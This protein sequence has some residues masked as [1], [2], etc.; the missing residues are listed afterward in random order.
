EVEANVA[1]GAPPAQL[2][3]RPVLAAGAD[4]PG[5][6]LAAGALEED[7]ARVDEPQRRPRLPE[8]AEEVLQRRAVEGAVPADDAVVLAA[9]AVGPPGQ[10][11]DGAALAGA[12]RPV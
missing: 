10:R 7:V 2:L 12:R 5:A 11:D 8:G 9:G 3:R 1:A 4:R 6:P